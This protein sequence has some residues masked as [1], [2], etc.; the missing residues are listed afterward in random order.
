[1][2]EC[3]GCL[4]NRAIEN[5]VR[6]GLAADESTAYKL[7]EIVAPPFKLDIRERFARFKLLGGP[8][9]YTIYKIWEAKQNG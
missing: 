3:G 1:M 4:E 9:A 6:I 2:C 7:L 5:L 8:H